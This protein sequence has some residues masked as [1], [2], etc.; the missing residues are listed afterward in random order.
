MEA[1]P[2]AWVSHMMWF[3]VQL[4]F[5]KSASVSGLETMLMKTSLE[6][7][8]SPV[9]SLCVGKTRSWWPVGRFWSHLA[10]RINKRNRWLISSCSFCLWMPVNF[11]FPF[12]FY[13]LLVCFRVMSSPCHLCS[14]AYVQLS[15]FLCSWC[16]IIVLSDN[17]L[18]LLMVCP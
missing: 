9:L 5:W 17:A 4:E 7:N 2:T 14:F 11:L 18:L 13:H 3:Y 8:L 12:V 10:I 15:A 16:Y 6:G 1:F